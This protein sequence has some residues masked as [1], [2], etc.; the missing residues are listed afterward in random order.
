MTGQEL[1]AA[2]LAEKQMD[3]CRYEA[4]SFGADPDLLAHLVL[5][6]EKTA[7]ASAYPLYAL[8][9]E[10]LP[11][12]GEYSVI[13]DSRDNA[14][15]VIQTTK[16]SVIPF[17][18]VTAAPCARGILQPVYVPSRTGVYPGYGRGF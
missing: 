6:G 8:E 3:D 14:V 13:L 4:W 1:W 11:A 5:S 12:A 10:M 7:T 16:V 18:R 17:D 2:F 15:C 9:D